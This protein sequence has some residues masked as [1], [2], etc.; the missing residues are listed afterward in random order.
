MV[1][2]GT[3]MTEFPGIQIGFFLEPIVTCSMCLVASSKF[4]WSFFNTGHLFWGVLFV[5]V[6]GTLIELKLPTTA[7]TGIGM[8]INI[9]LGEQ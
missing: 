5:L 4:C 9:Q 2:S 6:G 7:F 3:V 1:W 8:V